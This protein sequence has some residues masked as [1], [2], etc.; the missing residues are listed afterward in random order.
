MCMHMCVFV[1]NVDVSAIAPGARTS[2]KQLTW[3]QGTK[4]RPFGKTISA[5]KH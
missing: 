4:L 2:C 1:G 3:V 5:L